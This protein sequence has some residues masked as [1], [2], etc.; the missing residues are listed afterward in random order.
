[1]KTKAD[2]WWLSVTG[3]L[4][5]LFF[6]DVLLGKAALEYGFNPMLKLGDVGEFLVLFAAV[7]CFI[8]E[9]L[10]R[11]LQESELKTK[12]ANKAEEES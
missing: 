3:A 4:F 9:V 6:F 10:R 8:V 2:I 12:S 1:M 7:I 5:G 11:E